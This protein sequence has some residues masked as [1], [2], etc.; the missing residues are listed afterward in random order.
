M[1]VKAFD[2]GLKF[3]LFNRLNFDVDFYHKETC[4]MLMDI[5]YSFTTGF[6][7][8]YGNIG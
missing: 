6:A 3:G 2:L 7:S 5:P 4:D 1:S 8:G